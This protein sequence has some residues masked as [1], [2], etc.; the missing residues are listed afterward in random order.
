[1]AA[2]VVAQAVP[3]FA[4]CTGEPGEIQQCTGGISVSEPGG[5]NLGSVGGNGNNTEFQCNSDIPTSSGCVEFNSSGG[6]G[7]KVAG[8]DQGGFGYHCDPAFPDYECAGSGF[9]GQ[10]GF[11]GNPA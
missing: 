1:M 11:A 6:G 9:T 3:A 8:E 5:I 10:P 2:M 7:G 4:A